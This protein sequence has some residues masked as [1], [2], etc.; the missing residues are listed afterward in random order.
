[1]GKTTEWVFNQFVGLLMQ[2]GETTQEVVDD[3][4]ENAVTIT[5]ELKLPIS[6]AYEVYFKAKGIELD[7]GLI[8]KE[9]RGVNP[10]KMNVGLAH[11][12]LLEDGRRIH[13]I[14]DIFQDEEEDVCLVQAQWV[15]VG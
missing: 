11:M 4:K 9:V 6:Q 13:A 14:L 15:N 3:E 8:F 1:M 5:V 7:S 12:T 2:Y 10:F